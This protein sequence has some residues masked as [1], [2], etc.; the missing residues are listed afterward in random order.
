LAENPAQSV[1]KVNQLLSPFK[2]K[3]PNFRAVS[4]H[5]SWKKFYKAAAA[6]GF[7]R[8]VRLDDGKKKPSKYMALPSFQPQSDSGLSTASQILY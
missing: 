1:I 2:T 6:A 4:G 8:I 3:H 7:V 5:D